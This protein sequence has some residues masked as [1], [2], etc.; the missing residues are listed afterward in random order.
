[1]L[2]DGTKK[3]VFAGV[4][5]VAEI[6]YL[7]LQKVGIEL[8]DVLDN[9]KLKKGFFN[10]VIRP[11]EDLKAIDFDCIIITSFF[12]KKDVYSRLLEMGVPPEK[13]FF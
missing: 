9:E 5:E 7:S 8:V 10:Y 3:V 6:A 13:I 2:E 4:D 12:K 11:L 1:M